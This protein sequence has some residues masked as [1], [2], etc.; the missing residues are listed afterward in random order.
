MIFVN[1]SCTFQLFP[2]AS[3]TSPGL[4]LKHLKS[5]GFSNMKLRCIV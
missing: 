2:G 4:D 5:A 1:K 3:L